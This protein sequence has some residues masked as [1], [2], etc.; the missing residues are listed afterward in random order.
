M[1]VLLYT[2]IMFHRAKTLIRVRSPQED[3]SLAPSHT[4]IVVRLA[5]VLISTTTDL[6]LYSIMQTKKLGRTANLFITCRIILSFV[7]VAD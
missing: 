4:Q 7:F 6:R 2:G 3:R 5:V 1:F